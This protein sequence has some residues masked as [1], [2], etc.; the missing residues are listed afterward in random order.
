MLTYTPRLSPSG[1]EI[2]H[3]QPWLLMVLCLL[4][5]LPGLVGHD[6]WKPA[7]LVPAALVGNLIED[8][9]WGMTRLAGSAHLDVVPL[10]YWSAAALGLIWTKLGGAL[11]DGARIATGLWMALALWGMGLAGREL[12]GRGQGRVAVL[13]LLGCIGLVIWGHQ[14]GPQ[15]VLVAAFAWQMYALAYAIRRPLLAG[16]TLGFAWLLLLLGGGLGYFI[17]AVTAALLLVP[18]KPW[19]KLTFVVTLVSALIIAAPLFASW[20]VWLASRHPQVFE[21]W[22]QW[23][24]LTPFGGW[25]HVQLGHDPGYFI[26]SVLWLA[27]PA[28]PLALWTLWLRRDRF[29]SPHLLLPLQL[30]VLCVPWLALASEVNDA[31][32]LPLLVALSLLAVDGVDHLR[33]GAAAALGWF[34]VMLF[35][36]LLIWFWANWLA[37]HTGIPAALLTMLERYNPEGT[38]AISVGGLVFAVLVSIA[39]LSVVLRQRSYGRLAVTNWACGMTLVLGVLFGLWQ[40][41]LDEHKSYRSTSVALAGVIGGQCVDVS[42]AGE[43]MVASLDYFTRVHMVRDASCPLA[44]TRAAPATVEELVWR[45]ARRG[46]RN[47]EQFYLVRRKP[48]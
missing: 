42:E 48:A 32:I 11:H 31:L 13:V 14:L 39:W 24:A 33:R 10:Y 30:A 16:A 36:A 15:V 17:L 12:Y 20:L 3:Q 29:A 2:P 25:Q 22:W 28:W 6:P 23:R 43:A 35:G 41:W 18:F 8:G 9:R 45:G 37:L 34:G 47:N 40:G 4:W 46:A 7:E 21:F 38:R 26:S 5:L 44:L 27:F 19:R 1:P